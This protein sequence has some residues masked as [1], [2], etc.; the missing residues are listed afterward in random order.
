MRRS[1]GVKSSRWRWYLDKVFVKIDG[2]RHSLWRAADHA[3]EVQESFVTKS[4]DKKAALKLLKKAMRRHG[5]PEA[6]VTYKRRSCGAAPEEIGAENL[7]ETG[8]WAKN[9]AEN[10]HLLFRRRERV[11]Q[12]FRRMRSLQKFAS[13][14]V[15][16]PAGKH[17]NQ[18]RSLSK[19]TD[20]KLNRTAALAKW[21]DLLET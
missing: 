5:W 17:F 9:R 10:S 15:Q 12:R 6:F 8:R 4:R 2:E 13:V 11:M 1:E 21:R 14:H 3:G 7:R 18:A 16:A 19:R 20:I